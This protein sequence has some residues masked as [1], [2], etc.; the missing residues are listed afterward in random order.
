MLVALRLPPSLP[1]SFL[2]QGILQMIATIPLIPGAAGIS[3]IGA[4]TLYSRIVPTYLLGLFVVLW[5]LILY[6]LNIPLGLLA[7]TL[8]AREKAGRDPAGGGDPTEN[9]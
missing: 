9:L 6:Y 3:E 7:A 5:R 8:A 1:E 2:F 4:A